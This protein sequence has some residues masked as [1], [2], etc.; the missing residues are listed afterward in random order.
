[1]QY[2]VDRI[3]WQNAEFSSDPDFF[4][5]VFATLAGYQHPRTASLIPRLEEYKKA[6]KLSRHGLL[7]YA[8]GLQ[9]IG[10]LTDEY[11][12]EL[13][14]TMSA[15]EDAGSYWYWDRDADMSI[16]ASLL[17]ER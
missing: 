13:E 3:D 1:M 8:V 12:K 15:K 9:S 6:K 16:Y 4:A 17:I 5:E 7:M 2:L 11:M 14:T 10:K